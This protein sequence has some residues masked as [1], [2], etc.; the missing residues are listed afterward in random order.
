MINN[1]FLPFIVVPKSKFTVSQIV[2]RVFDFVK[3]KKLVEDK[4]CFIFRLRQISLKEAMSRYFSVI[5]QCR[6]MFLHQWKPKNNDA[7]LLPRALSLHG[8]HLLLPIT[9]H[10]KDGNG[11]D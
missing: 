11:L 4:L 1:A 6:N 2:L 9:Y 5:L 10:G 7:V 3:E 8:N